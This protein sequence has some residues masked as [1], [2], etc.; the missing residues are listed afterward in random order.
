MMKRRDN[1][2]ADVAG[3]DGEIEL[4]KMIVSCSVGDDLLA[5]EAELAALVE[6]RAAVVAG[7]AARDRQVTPV[8]VLGVRRA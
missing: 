3:I 8:R 4:V 1:A 2:A 6:R 7:A 5:R